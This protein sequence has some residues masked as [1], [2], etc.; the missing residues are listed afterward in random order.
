[1]VKHVII[2]TTEVESL[3]LDVTIFLIIVMAVL[4]NQYN[5]QGV[6]VESLISPCRIV[7]GLPEKSSSL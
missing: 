3:N 7:T 4:I 1:M 5:P 6:L 2:D